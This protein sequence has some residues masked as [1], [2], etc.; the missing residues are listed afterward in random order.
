M[1]HCAAPAGAAQQPLAAATRTEPRCVGCSSFACLQNNVNG[2]M[3]RVIDDADLKAELGVT[4][5][6][7]RKRILL[8]VGRMTQPAK[9]VA[10]QPARPEPVLASSAQRRS[11]AAE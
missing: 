8:A 2:T 10:A 1:R 6:L 9:A 11:L 5:G 3:L 7:H 4:S